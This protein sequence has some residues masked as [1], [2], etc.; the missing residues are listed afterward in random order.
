M[1]GGSYF[2]DTNLLL[3]SFDSRDAVKRENAR[4]GVAD[5]EA[6]EAVTNFSQWRPSGVTM[7]VVERA[8]YWVDR[9][10]LSWWNSLILASAASGQSVC[11]STG[12]R[13][14]GI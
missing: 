6:R 9:A 4:Q 1:P 14:Q 3:Y 2:A 5:T 12:F 13:R 11:P 10:E 8:W 7:A